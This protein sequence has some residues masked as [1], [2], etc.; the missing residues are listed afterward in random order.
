MSLAQC[1]GK[2]RG[3]RLVRRG[4]TLLEVIVVIAVIAVLA[5]VVGPAIVGNVGD[6]KSVAARQQIEILGLALDAY[7]LHNGVYPTSEQGLAALRVPPTSGAP[8]RDW[9]GPYLR[10]PVQPDP[11][12]REYVYASPGIH[13]PDGYDLYTLGRDGSPGGR[14]EDAD[15]TSWGGQL[16]E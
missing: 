4:F 10:R 1:D 2:P 16:R 13:S 12:G 3:G 9:R 6:A 15:I 8:A 14:G 11:W 7:R 5:A